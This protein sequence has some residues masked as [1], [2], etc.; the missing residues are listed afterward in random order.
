MNDYLDRWPSLQMLCEVAAQIGGLDVYAFGS[1]MRRDDPRDLDILI[2]YT[3]PAAL[4][5]LVSA[6]EWDLQVPPVDLIAMMPDEVV[7]LRFLDVTRA[8]KICASGWR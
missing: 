1:S 4:N 2:V 6:H 8:Q 3:D 7:E 5:S